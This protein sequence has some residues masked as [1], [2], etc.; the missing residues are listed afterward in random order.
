MRIHTGERPYKCSVCSKA[1]KTDGQ[2]REHFGSHNK[3]K[4]FQCPYCLKYYKRK[5]VVKNHILIHYSDPNFIEK[6][7][8]YKKIVDNLDNK[9]S[10]YLYDFYYKN[11]NIFST[12]EESQNNSPIVKKLNPEENSLKELANSDLL[13]R[14]STDGDSYE[15]KKNIDYE[16]NIEIDED[17]YEQKNSWING[18]N[19]CDEIFDNILKSIEEEKDNYL[20]KKFSLEN[21][22][23]YKNNTIFEDNEENTIYYH[24]IKEENKNMPLLEDII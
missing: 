20:D 11:T 21:V 13:N 18:N 10:I 23:K 8:F 7:D 3:E 15:N 14:S 2:L 6:K 1:F 9:N 4:P 17:E 19:N 24:E 5:G 22:N 16:K 12:K